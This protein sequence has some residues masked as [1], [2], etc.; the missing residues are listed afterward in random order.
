MKKLKKGFL[1]FILLF[2]FNE[3]QAAP[4][5]KHYAGYNGIILLYRPWEGMSFS[6]SYFYNWS[7]DCGASLGLMLRPKDIEEEF[8]FEDNFTVVAQAK[9]FCNFFDIAECIYLIGGFGG[10]LG[11]K[12]IDI[13]IEGELDFMPMSWLSIFMRTGLGVPLWEKLGTIYFNVDIG[14]KLCIDLF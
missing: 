10:S 13:E 1:T 14:V 2:M 5:L 8:N 9:I 7:R 11:I 3:V 4:C 6:M 12:I